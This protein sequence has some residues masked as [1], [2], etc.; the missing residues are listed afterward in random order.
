MVSAC[1]GIMDAP[2]ARVLDELGWPI[3][4]GPFGFF[5]PDSFLNR[6]LPAVLGPLQLNN[7]VVLPLFLALV[8]YDLA[9]TKRVHGATVVAAAVLFLLQPLAGWIARAFA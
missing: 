4:V 5:A 6:T 1:I 9:K 2:V 7:L 3:V 8:A